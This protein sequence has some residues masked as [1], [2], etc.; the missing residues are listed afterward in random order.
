MKR[1]RVAA[2]REDGAGAARER[3][4]IRVANAPCSWGL[5]GHGD[6]GI[7]YG[8]MLDELV[9]TGYEGTELGDYGFMPTD[10]EVLRDELASRHLTLLGAF[11]GV[12]LRDPGIVAVER[13]ML[14]RLATLLAEAEPSERRPYLVLADKDSLEPERK[15]NAGRITPEMGLTA[16]EWKV[17]ARNAEEVARLVAG[18]AGLPTVFHPHC[19][20]FVETRDEV[21]RFL[22]LTDPDLIGLVFDTG[23]HVYG[24]GRD[25]VDGLSAL[26]GLERY[27]QRVR[28]V[29]FKDCSPSVAAE[30]RAKGWDLTEAV[31]AGV[32]A[33]LGKGSVKFDA[34]L[35]FL[36]RHGYSDW[37]TV[38][39][40]VLPGMGTP[41][42]SARRNREYLRG[43]GI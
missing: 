30:A 17:F 37:I 24:S 38:E 25:D 18:V 27:W 1:Q 4:A 9:E 41:K 32:F 6:P 42:E 11:A 31:R 5:I 10:P 36:E 12:N 43:L 3:E 2:G 7:D 21:E 15:L 16:S 40:D 19:A 20:G 39:Q 29:H 8:S 33:E 23:H 22:E 13:P 14:E 35:D 28:Y 34:V 26:R